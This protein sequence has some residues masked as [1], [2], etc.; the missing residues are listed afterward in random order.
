VILHWHG[1]LYKCN[2]QF[3]N[4][5]FIKTKVTPP[6]FCKGNCLGLLLFLFIYLFIMFGLHIDY[7]HSWWRLSITALWTL[8][9]I[10]TCLT[11]TH[12]YFRMFNATL[13]NISVISWQSCV[14]VEKTREPGVNHWQT[15][16][17]SIY[18]YR[19]IFIYIYSRNKEQCLDRPCYLPKCSFSQS[20][21]NQGCWG[22]MEIFLS[23]LQ[24][25]INSR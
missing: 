20:N 9:N 17:H 15:L 14:L 7:E 5:T 13:N 25:Y 24:I 19:Y 22:R 2:V 4:N 11:H 10:P 6:N 8:N 21:P 23:V 1:A 18:T 12:I 16:L 3:L